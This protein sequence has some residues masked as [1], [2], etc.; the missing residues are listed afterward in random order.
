VLLQQLQS[1]ASGASCGTAM[2][3]LIFTELFRCDGP[4]TP[5]PRRASAP[6]T[7]T[8][9][10]AESAGQTFGSSTSC[11]EPEG[12]LL[13]VQPKTMPQVLVCTVCQRNSQARPTVIHALAGYS[14]TAD[15]LCRCC[16]LR[17]QCNAARCLLPTQLPQH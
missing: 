11:G 5:G 10:S 13:R 16:N 2:S 12:P 14:G 9:S 17:C 7:G 6:S 3:D 1:P 8:I 15:D 4:H